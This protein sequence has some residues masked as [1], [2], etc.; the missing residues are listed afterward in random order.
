MHQFI[1]QL[2]LKS[3]N[4]YF[5]SGSASQVY[6][7][8]PRVQPPPGMSLALNYGIYRARKIQDSV[9]SVGYLVL[10]KNEEQDRDQ[11][12][13]TC[14]C[15]GKDAKH[16]HQ[17]ISLRTCSSDCAPQHPSNPE[18]SGVERLSAGSELLRRYTV[19]Y[20][21]RSHVECAE[22]EGVER[23]HGQDDVP[24]R[25]QRIHEHPQRHSRKSCQQQWHRSQ[26]LHQRPGYSD[27]TRFC[28]HRYDPVYPLQV[29]GYPLLVQEDGEKRVIWREQEPAHEDGEE[30]DQR[31]GSEINPE[32]TPVEFG[33]LASG[34]VVGKGQSV[35]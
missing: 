26:T 11:N 5:Q 18:Q 24:A 10:S 20:L 9:A 8:A 3:K 23:L 1:C 15:Y 6:L 12:H 19:Y 28:A 17:P 14:G 31:K 32:A 29:V 27:Q 13:C 4:A 2:C 33:T 7:K 21:Y 25:L 16:A 35:E 30:E 34:V 22:R